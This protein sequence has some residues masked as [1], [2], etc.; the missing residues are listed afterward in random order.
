MEKKPL[1]L[2][3][4]LKGEKV[5]LL[6]DSQQQKTDKYGRTLSYVYRM[7]DGLF[8]N[9]EIIRQGYGHAYTEYPFYYQK[10]FQQLEGFAKKSQKGLWSSAGI[11]ASIKAEEK[12]KTDESNIIVY[13][14]KTGSKYH[15][16]GCLY[17]SE[18][19]IPISLKEAK[20]RYGPCSVCNPPQ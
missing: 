3:N 18:S 10:Q 15:R 11:T 4:L 1:F 2:N 5:C 16:S 8:V 17:L 7:P 19:S 12:S 20:V 6:T 9:A 13:I 14:T